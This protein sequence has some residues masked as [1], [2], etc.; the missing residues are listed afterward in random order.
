M[1]NK[2]GINKL[3][4]RLSVAGQITRDEGRDII[5]DLQAHFGRVRQDVEHLLDHGYWRT[6]RAIQMPCRQ[7]VEKLHKAAARI[8]ARIKAMEKACK[9]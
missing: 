5:L 3:I 2:A 9:A 6:V 4:Q 7:Q 1:I 8:E